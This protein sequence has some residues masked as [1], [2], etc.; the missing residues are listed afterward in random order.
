MYFSL[1][2]SVVQL[3]QSCDLCTSW[4]YELHDL[5]KVIPVGETHHATQ[6][7]ITPPMRPVSASGAVSDHLTYVVDIY[8]PQMSLK[9]PFYRNPISGVMHSK[10]KDKGERGALQPPEEML[11]HATAPW[12]PR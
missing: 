6:R 9:P 10:G 11:S 7:R 5:Y 4:L 2:A 3:L 1:A 12:L 8:V